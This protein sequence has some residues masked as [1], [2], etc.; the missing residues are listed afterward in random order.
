[1]KKCRKIRAQAYVHRRI[2]VEGACLRS[3]R[4][5]P[6]RTKRTRI[7][8]SLSSNEVTGCLCAGSTKAKGCGEAKQWNVR[9]R[10]CC[11]SD[12]GMLALRVPS[13][14]LSTACGDPGRPP[15]LP[16]GPPARL[17]RRRHERIARGGCAGDWG[18]PALAALSVPAF[19]S[20]GWLP[21]CDFLA[22]ALVR[23]RL[24]AG[25]SDL[26]ISGRL[27]NPEPHSPARRRRDSVRGARARWRNIATGG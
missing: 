24:R 9:T 8:G 18:A 4:K 2:R 6:T 23:C 19:A 27:R 15:C 21:G 17:A 26:R 3:D 10:D 25:I 20:A 11:S 22:R 14:I 1:M 13:P 16:A 12:L 7:V 5:I